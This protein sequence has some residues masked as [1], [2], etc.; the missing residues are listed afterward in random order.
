MGVLQHTPGL[1]PGHTHDRG[2]K[3]AELFLCFET[4]FHVACADLKISA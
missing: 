3:I 1:T 2:T 4:E